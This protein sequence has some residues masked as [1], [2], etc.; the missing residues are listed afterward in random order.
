MAEPDASAAPAPAAP[1]PRARRRWPGRLA[2]ALAGL[3]ALLAALVA[4]IGIGV[5]SDAGHR[6]IV[7]RI[8]ELRPSTGLRIHI[9][10][11]EGSIWRHA[12]LRDLR[13][14]DP[15]GLFLEAPLVT[16]D[17][18]PTRWFAHRLYVDR[19]GSDLVIL[20]RLPRLRPSAHP[21]PLI[22]GYP[23]HLGAVDLRLRLEPPVAGA[24]RLVRLRAR[25]DTARGR[26][27][28]HLVAASTAGDRLA[29]RLDTAPAQDRFDLDGRLTAPAT[30]VVPGLFGARR[31]VAMAISGTGRWRGWRGRARLRVAGRS[32]ADLA[33]A[34]ARGDYAL[35]GLVTPASLVAGKLQRLTSPAVRVSGRAH[36]ADRQLTGRLAL[37]APALEAQAQ[38]RIDLAASRFDPLTVN[39]AL[40]R[41]AALFPNMTGR[42]VRLRA[43][44]AGPFRTAAFRYALTAPTLAFDTTGFEAVRAAGE[45]RLGGRALDLPL[46][47][48]ARRV[49]G[50]GA[51]AGGIL[52]NLAVSGRLRVTPRLVTGEGLSLRS[53][54]L[55]G[56]LAL[57]VDLVTGRFGVTLSGGLTRYLIPNLGLVDVLTELAVRPTADTR[58]AIVEGRGRAWVRRFDNGFL[59]GLAGGLPMLETHLVRQPDGG[60]RLTNLTVTAPALRISGAGLRRRDGSFQFEGSGSQ[61][62]YGP[63]RLALDGLI[64]HPQVRLLL[65][66]P[67]PAL[68]LA[69]VRVALDPV[70]E[71]FALQ[72]QGGSTLGPF[73]LGGRILTPPQ[74]P[75]VIDVAALAVSGTR[76]TGRL[77]AVGPVLAG[78]LAV[79]GGGLTGTIDLAAAQA[80]QRIL[81]HIAAAD[82]RL[83]GDADL[84]VRRGRA[85]A[86]IVLD[87]AATRVT[88]QVMAR[89]L[90][91]G[92][93]FL[94]RADGQA[95]LAGGRGLIHASLA[96]SRGKAFSFDTDI[97]VAPMQYRLRGGGQIDGRPVTLT[98]PATLSRDGAG[99]RLEP[100]GLSYGGGGATVAGRFGAGPNRFEASLSALPLT[101]LDIFK[102]G[103]ALSGAA[104]G[105]ISYGRAQ[106]GALPS[107]RV[108]LR[109]RG[110]S[111]AGLVLSSRPVDLGV[112]AALTGDRAALRA[113]AASG[114]QV[115][116]RA[117]AALGPLP[118][119][120]TLAERFAH[121]G[122]FGQLRYAG[123]IDTLWRLSGIETIDLS[124]PVAI[125]ADI[126]GRVDAPVIRG[127]LATGA[128]RLE[129]ATLGT[130]IEG[131]KGRGRFD[132]SRL[133]IDQFSGTT[134]DDGALSGQASFDF[135]APQGLGI[136]IALTARKAL[137]LNRDDIA[138]T[139]T[140]PLT[141][142]SNGR[143]GA[144][145]GAVRL[146]RATYR[147]GSVAA[148]AVPH[149]A[150]T[151]LNRP[152]DVEPEAAPA[153]WSLD[154]TTDARNQLFVRGLGLDSEWRAKLQIRGTV[155]NPAI[156]GRADMI[157]GSYQFAGRRFDLDRGIIRFTGSQPVDPALDIAAIASISNL[158]ATIRVSGTGSKPELSFTSV[159]ALP[160]DELLS[161][162]LF[163]TSIANLS[164]PEALQLAAAVNALRTGGGRGALDPINA[165][166]RVAGLDRLRIEAADVTTGQKTSIAAG[167]YIGR[168][169][170]VELV[171]DGQGYSATRIEFQVTRWLSLL[172]TISTIGRQ[173]AN[174][175]ISK[176]Y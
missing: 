174:V 76:A 162:L 156:T 105:R 24:R 117:Q 147:F 77:T 82:A 131:I 75:T 61:T 127:S 141:I 15:Q 135:A 167:K 44:L 37:K 40:R 67:V 62:S 168:R 126:S 161:R 175:R 65:D 132:G 94:A 74:Q 39:L 91:R 158:N 176:D 30:G 96:G 171:T 107:G 2:R 144:I 10:R 109:V 155:D 154:L 134:R 78:R 5:D 6:F 115:I 7:D 83:A 23:I 111:R 88:A 80:L 51:E 173:S 73:T 13:L 58:A 89:G 86:D 122:L 34:E 56:R 159:P 43:R 60:L 137:L 112:E 32:V 26:A 153:P 163:G 81:V 49:T 59:R 55:N 71:G 66:R 92:T 27:L 48:T 148:T 53:D 12:R 118:P 124:G 143:G 136:D 152:A 85:D 108:T 99:W 16:L 41:P 57:F 128:A 11:I 170:Y 84:T 68:G 87:P 151:E 21:Q 106:E 149:L 116:G 121:A 50:V 1:P 157:R 165:I 35:S 19:L 98:S 31:P 28:I 145:S 133:V 114:G 33:L 54:K 169:T 101:M 100:T 25:A 52:A 69:G 123:P 146:D 164:A 172:S 119:G 72:A 47:L 29:F 139:V 70:P 102:P 45:G 166:R 95:R 20:R 120:G 138:A 140:G 3:V 97:D 104:S 93:I 103:L 129:S 42:D 110:L 125:G 18:R 142:R 36:Y 113:V 17:W 130:V 46:R 22:P 8:G 90:R 38:G 63:F 160:E 9:G 79:A 150:V 14:S 64:D 4:V